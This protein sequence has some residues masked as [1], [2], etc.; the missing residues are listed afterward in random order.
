MSSPNPTTCLRTLDLA[1]PYTCDCSAA[2]HGLSGCRECRCQARGLVFLLCLPT[3][4]LVA[5]GTA[6]MPLALVWMGAQALV[7]AL[8]A[9]LRAG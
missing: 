6:L 4:V 2:A 7:R 9:W 5:L 1:V 8:R 3:L